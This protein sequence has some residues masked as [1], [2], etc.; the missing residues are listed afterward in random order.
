M[1]ERTIEITGTRKQWIS[2]S[3]SSPTYF[4]PEARFAGQLRKLTSRAGDLARAFVDRMNR[5][6][7]PDLVGNHG[8][9]IVDE[10]LEADRARYPECQTILAGADAE[11]VNVAGKP[12]HRPPRPPTC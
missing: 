1:L 8:D 2:R 7:R 9:D 5:E 3:P 4:G 12:R 10:G 6:V 11:L